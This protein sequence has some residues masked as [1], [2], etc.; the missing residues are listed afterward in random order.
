MGT[1]TGYP[2]CSHHNQ[3]WTQPMVIRIVHTRIMFTPGSDM[4]TA[5]GYPDWAHQDQ[6]WAQPMVI[7]I[8]HTRIMFTPGSD[9]GTA[10]SY[11][12]WSHQDQA[13]AQPLVIRTAHTR[14]R[15]WHSHWLSGLLAPGSGMGT[16]TG[17][18]DWAQPLVIWTSHTRIRHGHSHWLSG[19]LMISSILDSKSKKGGVSPHLGGQDDRPPTQSTVSG[20]RTLEGIR[21]VPPSVLRRDAGSPTERNDKIF[22]RV[23]G[24]LNKLTPEKFD[25]LSL[26][27]LNVG[28]DNP[29]VLKGIILLVFEK[30]LEE[31]K[32]SKLYAQLC[33]RLCEDVPNFEP[34]SSGITSFRRLLLNKCQDEFENRSK[35]TEVFDK[36]DGP[37]TEDE[38]EQYHLAKEKMLGNIKFIG[39]LGK[40]E[41]LHEGI[42]HKCIRQLLEKKKNTPLRDMEEDMECLCQIMRTIGPLLDTAK[43]KAWMKQ[44]FSRIEVFAVNEELPPRIRFMLQDVIELK[45]N[46]WNPRRVATENG[47]KT[48]TAIRKE[49]SDRH[50]HPSGKVFPNSAQMNGIGQQWKDFGDIFSMP[51]GSMSNA[52]GAGPGVI[53]V[54]SFAPQFGPNMG[55]G[56]GGRGGGGGG[57]GGMGRSR[58]EQQNPNF[59]NNYRRGNKENDN[60]SPQ[61]QR[62]NS[63]QN[64]RLGSPQSQR[65]IS[66]PGQRRNIPIPQHNQPAISRQGGGGLLS[67]KEELSL[68]PQKNFMFKPNTPAMLPRSAQAAPSAPLVPP[69]NN[70]R[71]LGTVSPKKMTVDVTTP[72]INPTL[73]KQITIKPKEEKAKPPKKDSLTQEE[74]KDKVPDLISDF[75]NQQDVSKTVATIRDLDIPKRMIPDFLSQFLVGSV[76]RSEAEQDEVMKLV[77]ALKTEKLITSDQFIESFKMVAD[78]MSA[79]EQETPLVKSHVARFG[80]QALCGQVSS[81]EELSQPFQ[82]GAHYPLF[83]LCLQC[84]HR[85]QDKPWLVR[86]FNHSKINLQDMLPETDQK[87]E[88]MLEILEDRGLSFLFP[89]MRVQSELG[90]QIAAEP[91]AGA[92]FKWIKERVD[93]ELFTNSNF[94]NILVTSMV[95]Y[96]TGESTMKESADSSVTPDKA[97]MD[98]E[99]ELLDK[100]RGVLQKFLHEH[101]D[102]QVAAL[103]AVQVFCHAH[104]FPKGML[105]RFFVNLYD[106]SIVEEEAFLHW[107]EEVNDQ[108]PGKGTALFQVNQW[109]TWLEQAEEESEDEE[110]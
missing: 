89:L 60:H 23:R 87:K 68:R 55:G 16:A 103:Y 15:H 98:K 24:I 69:S 47:P 36:K 73:H 102:L 100:L 46:G 39:E 91:S 77:A 56:G 48:I 94:I 67:S 43:A 79:L 97:V 8:V 53:Q 72:P 20:F 38:R 18:L 110:D 92:I 95:K 57:G 28:I 2:D 75:F 21:W 3:A 22:R 88:R 35:A 61:N 34:S 81:L 5:T 33:H 4:G 40:L 80:A 85:L 17:Y 52:I 26:E 49:A 45:K 76:S 41:M 7:R 66:P 29:P 99:K 62:R 51:V 27:L 96:I 70:L 58:G 32:Y 107:K 65:R 104:Q 59:Q 14:I 106:Q 19:M 11:W 83:L 9:M 6:A 12:E 30:A 71:T 109:L 44:Y 37:L 108:Y 63:P 42:L 31:P 64:P 93:P 1:A 82:N 78:Q 10:N 50:S 105:L 101:I 25:K 54:D 86:L 90:R 84:A 13:W 74:L